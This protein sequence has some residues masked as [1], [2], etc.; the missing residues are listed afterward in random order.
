MTQHEMPEQRSPR[1]GGEEPMPSRVLG[2]SLA[3]AA[4]CVGTGA[5]IALLAILGQP[6]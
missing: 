2:H 4:V 3:A 6:G 1:E 5:T